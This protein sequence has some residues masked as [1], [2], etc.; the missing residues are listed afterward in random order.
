MRFFI[1]CALL[2]TLNGCSG[3]NGANEPVPENTPLPLEGNREAK[4]KALG[5]VKVGTTDF[6]VAKD[7]ASLASRGKVNPFLTLEEEKSF[8]FSGREVLSDIKLSAIFYSDKDSYA[9]MDGFIVREGDMF[10]AKSVVKI[11]KN[12]VILKDAVSEYVVPVENE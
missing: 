5:K 9:I 2:L 3:C 4:E 6:S 12:A 8:A 1:M 7:A 11:E 10:G